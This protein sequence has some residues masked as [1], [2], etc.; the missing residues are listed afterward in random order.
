MGALP[1]ALCRLL[2]LIKKKCISEEAFKV[3]V[4]LETHFVERNDDWVDKYGDND[5]APLEE[6]LTVAHNVTQ[7]A[8]SNIDL[9]LAR[10]LYCMVRCTLGLKA[11]P[12]IA[13]DTRFI[14]ATHKWWRHLSSRDGGA[15]RKLFR[16]GSVH[17]QSLLRRQRPLFLRGP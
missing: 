4:N 17:D 6:T 11:P 12:G 9:N 14:L 15:V 13:A 16:P 5:D 2:L 10:Q 3:I 1:R 8:R 7:V